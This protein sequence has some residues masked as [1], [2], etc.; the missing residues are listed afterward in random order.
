[1]R[2]RD[3]SRTATALIC[4]MDWTVVLLTA[5]GE[6]QAWEMYNDFSLGYVGL[7]VYMGH[8]SEDFQ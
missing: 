5:V 8:P 3:C 4:A 7:E 1:M 6:K 2:E